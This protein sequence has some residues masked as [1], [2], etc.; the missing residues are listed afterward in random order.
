[1]APICFFF[2]LVLDKRPSGNDQVYWTLPN[3]DAHARLTVIWT[4]PLFLPGN[5]PPSAPRCSVGTA[6]K[7]RMQYSSP[8]HMHNYVLTNAYTCSFFL[9][10]EGGVDG[11]EQISIFFGPLQFNMRL[12]SPKVFSYM[13]VYVKHKTREIR[14]FRNKMLSEKK[15]HTHIHVICCHELISQRS[16][17]FQ[18][19]IHCCA[20][21]YIPCKIVQI[22]QGM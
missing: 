11:A 15:N 3:G 2:S 1:M 21:V 10:G 18:S 12:F 5:L 16:P 14:L 17:F 4:H 22:L 20:H 8:V 19:C 9:V 7:T 13:H 6:I